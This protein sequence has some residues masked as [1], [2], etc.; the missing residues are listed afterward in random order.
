MTERSELPP[1]VAWM[2]DLP[3]PHSLRWVTCKPEC[4]DGALNVTPLYT[5]D[6]LRAA[7]AQ[8]EQQTEVQQAIWLDDVRGAV[9][10]GWCHPKNSHTQMD[11]DLA[12]A[13]ADEVCALGAAPVRDEENERLR[14][15]GVGYLNEIAAINKENERLRALLG[16][17]RKHV[18]IAEVECTSCADVEEHQRIVRSC[19]GTPNPYGC[20][21]VLRA[22]IDAALRGKE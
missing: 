19:G 17:A 10:R 22:R 11:V 12:L 4:L 21:K 7:V 2:Y 8:R 18:A 5:A 3:L 9:A 15:L 14:A 16:E 13:I 1:P 6:Q 20:C